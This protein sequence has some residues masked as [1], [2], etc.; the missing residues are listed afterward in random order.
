MNPIKGIDALTPSPVSLT[1]SSPPKS[2]GTSFESVLKEAVEKV[3]A[4]QNEAEKAVEELVTGGD[5]A[6]AVIAMEKADLSFQMMIE[7]RN[8]LINAYEEIMRL[9]V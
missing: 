5:V 3:G 9:Q 2:G 4:I 6:S 7:I 8:K 1:K